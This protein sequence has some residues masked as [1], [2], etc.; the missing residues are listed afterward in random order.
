MKAVKSIVE[1]A[2][3]P[4]RIEFLIRLDCDDESSVNRIDELCRI[5]DQVFTCVG[6]P[7]PKHVPRSTL[8]NEMIQN[9]VGN[10]LNFWSDDMLLLGKGWDTQLAKQPMA[11]VIVHPKIYK[12]GA[13][14]EYHY[15]SGGPVPFIPASAVLLFPQ[16]C[17]WEPPDTFI[18]NFLI[19]QEKWKEVWMEGITVEHERIADEILPVL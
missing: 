19:T 8:W 4:S 10:W 17:L 1:S 3:D 7:K 2:D 15:T 14:T 12:L 16:Q 18:K 13:E 6:E 9:A 5:H 11:G